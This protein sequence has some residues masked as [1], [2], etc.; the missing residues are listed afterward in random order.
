MKFISMLIT[1]VFMSIPI[2][3]IIIS[4]ALVTYIENELFAF[5]TSAIFVVFCLILLIEYTLK[6]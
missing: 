1:F 2:L 3:T 4:N 6:K 5:I